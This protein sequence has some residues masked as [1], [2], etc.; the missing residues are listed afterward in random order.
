MKLR[1]ILLL[2]L[3][4]PTNASRWFQFPKAWATGVL[5]RISALPPKQRAAAIAASVV[6]A[7]YIPYSMM[8]HKYAEHVLRQMLSVPKPDDLELLDDVIGA[9]NDG[10]DGNNNNYPIAVPSELRRT[11]SKHNNLVTDPRDRLRWNQWIARNDQ[12]LDTVTAADIRSLWGTT[13]SDGGRTEFRFKYRT[14][15]SQEEIAAWCKPFWTWQRFKFTFSRTGRMVF[16]APTTDDDSNKDTLANVFIQDYFL[17]RSLRRVHVTWYGKVV[18]SNNNKE[19]KNPN[20]KQDYKYHIE[21]TSTEAKSFL[22]WTKKS[23]NIIIN[24]EPSKTM[25]KIPWDIVKMEDKMICLRRG[26]VGY[27]VYD[28]N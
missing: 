26:D 25:S 19:K 3:A 23:P 11:V 13:T 7:S 27:L 28:S 4:S 14:G 16:S 12:K 20:S 24:N 21:W 18:R 6:V 17:I 5:K 1:N 2:L 15:A 10:V 8:V 9:A 22:P